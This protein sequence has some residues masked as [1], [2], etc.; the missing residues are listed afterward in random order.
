MNRVKSF[1]GGGGHRGAEAGRACS[2]AASMVKASGSPHHGSRQSALV[3]DKEHDDAMRQLARRLEP[4]GLLRRSWPLAGGVSAEVTAFE[5]ERLDGR[6]RRLILRRHGEEDRR[7]NPDIGRDE[8]RLLQIAQAHGL[9]APK[10]LLFDESCQLFPT[11]ILVIDWVDGETE[12]APLD[13]DGFLAQAAAQLAKIHSMNNPEELSFLPQHECGRDA[14]HTELDAS[15]GEGDIREALATA[16]P[17][18]QVN[19]RVLLHGD[20]WPGN[21]LWKDGVLAAVI[22]W[23]DAAVGDPRDDLANARLE[24]LWAFGTE[25]MQAFTERYD[26]MTA[27]DLTALPYWDLCA[28]LRPCGKMAGWPLD[29]AAEQR[30]RERH[31]LFVAQALLALRG[32]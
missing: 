28:A 16:G 26:S 17:V 23:E 31:R 4:G 12:F 22:D 24:M 21:I 27:F 6:P 13:L 1:M 29:A 20:Y 3:T 8:F 25:A 19:Q 15:L 11:P 30:M 9:V 5:I 2:R 7:R 32:R 18:P 10:P 14:G